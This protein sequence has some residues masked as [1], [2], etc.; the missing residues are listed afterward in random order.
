MTGTVYVF[1]QET[2][3]LSETFV[4]FQGQDLCSEGEEESGI[5]QVSVLQ[6]KYV[7]AR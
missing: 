6:L 5:Q 4:C 1:G 7:C 2:L 3:S